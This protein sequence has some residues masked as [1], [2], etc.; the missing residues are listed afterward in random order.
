[1]TI[2]IDTNLLVYAS[3]S[4]HDPRSADAA[5]WLERI[6]EARVPIAGQ[7]LSEFLNVAHRK[8]P[9]LIEKARQTVKM[10]SNAFDVIEQSLEDRISASSLAEARSIQFY[11]ALLISTLARSGVH[12]LLSEDM[13]DGDTYGGVTVLNPFNPANA[14]RIAAALQ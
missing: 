3:M 8:H 12:T 7:M 14:A 11:D 13:T 9:R 10:F 4:P 6:L 1:V 2:S 5:N